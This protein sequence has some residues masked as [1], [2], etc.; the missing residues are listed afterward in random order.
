M[1]VS[2][3]LRKLKKDGWFF[4]RHGKRHDLYRHP[5]KENE[6]PLPRHQNQE[7]KK[8]TERSILKDA[9]LI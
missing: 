1:K 2:E 7:L 6:I 8:G 4:H 9:G 5:T 3:M